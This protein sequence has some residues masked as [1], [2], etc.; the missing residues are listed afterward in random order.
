MCRCVDIPYITGVEKRKMMFNQSVKNYKR[1]LFR[2]KTQHFSNE[3]IFGGKYI[4][5]CNLFLHLFHCYLQ[6]NNEL[7]N[8]A[9]LDDDYD[10][11]LIVS[12]IQPINLNGSV[13]EESFINN[14]I[15]SHIIV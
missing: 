4:V 7:Q 1:L 9:A 6:E 11:D 5:P 15:G 8:D 12:P 2:L 10:I 14:Q 13:H 3:T